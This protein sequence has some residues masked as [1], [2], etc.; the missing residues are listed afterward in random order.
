MK[1]YPFCRDFFVCLFLIASCKYGLDSK[2][3]ANVTSSYSSAFT[4][5][6]LLR[7]KS[8]I[9][10]FENLLACFIPLPNPFFFFPAPKIQS[11]IEVEQAG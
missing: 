8:V 7:A 5:F 11:F 9:Y 2:K 10:G 4:F 1:Q 3:A 6:P